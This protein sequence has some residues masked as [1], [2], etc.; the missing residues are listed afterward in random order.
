[1][2][3]R[4]SFN[5]YWICT[6]QDIDSRSL[7]GRTPVRIVDMSKSAASER[8]QSAS[9]DGEP[10]TNEPV[11]EAD[12]ALVKPENSETV[13]TEVNQP[14]RFNEAIAPV[15]GVEEPD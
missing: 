7:H 2:R 11:T 5:P 6:D 9:D 14:E 8:P 10:D 4:L 13:Q 3:M 15:P 1:M 12:P